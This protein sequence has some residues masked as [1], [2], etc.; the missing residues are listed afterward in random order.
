MV[1]EKERIVQESFRTSEIKN[2]NEVFI[3][4]RGKYEALYPIIR[5]EDHR[6][7]LETGSKISEDR[8]E[9]LRREISEG[10]RKANVSPYSFEKKGSDL[11]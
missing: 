11:I 5:N 4:I 3:K 9:R 6:L 8:F 10:L 1:K 7:M 2:P